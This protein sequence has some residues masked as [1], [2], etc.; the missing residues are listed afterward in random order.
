[1]SIAPD[2]VTHDGILLAGAEDAVWYPRS[3]GYNVSFRNKPKRKQNRSNTG[4]TRL[5]YIPSD[6][7]LIWYCPE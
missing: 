6:N 5:W 2:D 4:A 3:A 1:M 7:Y